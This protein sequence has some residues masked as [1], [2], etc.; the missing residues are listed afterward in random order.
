MELCVPLWYELVLVK[1]GRVA[2][3]RF[4]G[5]LGALSSEPDV[6]LYS[7]LLLFGG[8]KSMLALPPR[9]SAR[10]PERKSVKDIK[11]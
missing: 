8:A 11:Q 7:D 9:A 3:L 10:A 1:V 6:R 5:E 4:E 2:A